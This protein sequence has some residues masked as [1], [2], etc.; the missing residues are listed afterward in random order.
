MFYRTFGREVASVFLRASV[1]VVTVVF[2]F[3]FVA[4]WY[5]LESISD[6]SCNIAVLPIEGAILPFTGFADFPLITTPSQVRDF[7][8]SAESDINI[9]GILIEINSPGGTPVAS[10][11][12]S[13]Y[14]RLSTLPV[15]ATIG[16]IGASGAYLVAASADI[17]IASAMSDVG[18]IG[19]TM[20]YLEASEKNAEEGLTFVELNSG[21]FKDAGNPDKPLTPAERA[22]FERDLEIVHDEFVRQIA[23]LRNKDVAEIEALADGSSMPGIRALEVGLVDR[24]GG[25]VEAREEFATRLNLTED[26][27][28]FCE[29]ESG[30]ELV[31]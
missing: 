15:V 25:R 5:Q 16:D 10:E 26:A 1:L 20:S 9:D 13:Q 30:F 12:I 21:E 11:Q 3:V 8:A 2:L 23:T 14:L 29:Y 22:I 19:V 18:S 6:G 7:I 17:I 27:I 31:Y 24:L 28:V 4:S